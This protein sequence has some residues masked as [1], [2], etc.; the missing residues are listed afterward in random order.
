[1]SSNNVVRLIVQNDVMS[2]W[3]VC[4]WWLE[5]EYIYL[6]YTFIHSG[7]AGEF[8]WLL[9]NFCRYRQPSAPVSVTLRVLRTSP[10]AREN[11]PHVRVTLYVQ[12]VE[13][14]LSRSTLYRVSSRTAIFKERL[15]DDAGLRFLCACWV[16]WS[17]E[18]ISRKTCLLLI[19]WNRLEHL[20]IYYSYW[21]T[22]V[23]QTR[24]LCDTKFI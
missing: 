24:N 1:M 14:T 7:R 5:K 13:I 19:S 8:A 12:N 17:D 22:C 16:Q 18:A 11:F 2:A 4:V 23:L 9:V 3:W 6:R 10:P 15:Y 20:C 21:I